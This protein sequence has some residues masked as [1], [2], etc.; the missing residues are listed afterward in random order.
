MKIYLD[1]D[2][3]G[4]DRAYTQTAWAPNAE[5]IIRWYGTKS[6]DVRSRLKHHARRQRKPHLRRLRLLA[7]AGSSR[8][9]VKPRDTDAPQI[10]SR[11]DR[12]AGRDLKSE[13]AALPARN[14]PQP[15]V[16]IKH[17]LQGA[18]QMIFLQTRRHL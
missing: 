16:V 10:G 18:N 13:L 12:A 2:Q 14:K 7:D 5:E 4:L 6:A 9:I 15:V 3:A 1:Y 17:R 11:I 8:S